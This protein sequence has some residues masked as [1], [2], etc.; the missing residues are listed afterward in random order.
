MNTIKLTLHIKM[1]KYVMSET[2][3]KTVQGGVEE[4]NV[5]VRKV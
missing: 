3:L 4:K 5:S 1:S 2:N